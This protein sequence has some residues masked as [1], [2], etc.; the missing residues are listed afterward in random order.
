MTMIS[1]SNAVLAPP[2]ALAVDAMYRLGRTADE[3]AQALDARGIRGVPSLPGRCPL[4]VFVRREIARRGGGRVRVTVSRQDV[5][6]GGIVAGIVAPLP[7]HFTALVH[8]IDYV[9]RPELLVPN[10]FDE[11]PR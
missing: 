1:R 6:V 4:A 7:R 2:R 10:W 8:Q 11:V 9:M 5:F 3:V